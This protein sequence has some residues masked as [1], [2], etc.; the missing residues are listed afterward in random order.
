MKGVKQIC[1]WRGL[2]GVLIENEIGC[3]LLSLWHHF[4]KWDEVA[5]HTSNYLWAFLV[6][7]FKNLKNKGAAGLPP[8]HILCVSVLCNFKAM[9]VF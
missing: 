4:C 9:R 1:G 2:R 8:V 7:G 3:F 5:L 6:L